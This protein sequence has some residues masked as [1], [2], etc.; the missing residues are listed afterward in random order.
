MQCTRRQLFM[1]AEKGALAGAATVVLLGAAVV[2]AA[3]AAGPVDL[4]LVRAQW[5]SAGREFALDLDVS[6]VLWIVPALGALA[7]AVWALRSRRA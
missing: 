2:L 4:G 1:S 7:G 3:V 6:A 5:V